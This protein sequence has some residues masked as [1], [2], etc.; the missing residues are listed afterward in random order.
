MDPVAQGLIEHRETIDIIGEVKL[1]LRDLDEAWQ[2]END[3]RT[4]K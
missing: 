2:E 3:A 1:W 4:S